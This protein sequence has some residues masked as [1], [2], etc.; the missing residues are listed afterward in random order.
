MMSIFR[1]MKWMLSAMLAA[2]VALPLAQPSPA[3][4]NVV[5]IDV[6]AC[7]NGISILV[8]QEDA[9]QPAPQVDWSTADGKGTSAGLVGKITGS[10]VPNG[11][12]AQFVYWNSIGLNA[13][14]T[15]QVIARGV[16]NDAYARFSVDGE[17]PPL[18]SVR[19]SAFEDLNHNGIRDAGE[20][21]IGT[22]SWKLT[23]GGDWFICGYVG[24]DSTFGPTVTPGTYT[25]IP[26]AQPGWVATTPPRSALVKRLGVAALDNDIGFAR[27]ANSKGQYCSQYA[28]PANVA[29]PLPAPAQAPTD[30]LAANGVFT[31]LLAGLNSTGLA[32][33]VNGPGAYTIIAPTDAA[34]A[35][36]SPAT[37]RRLASNP[38]ALEELLRCH[39]ILGNVDLGSLGPRAKAFPTLGARKVFLQVRNGQLLVNGVVV[40]DAI[41]TSNGQI[42]VPSRVL[43]V[44]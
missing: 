7:P 43:F 9:T 22:A 38:K 40:G 37:Q 19:G 5:G 6:F 39:I 33:V 24:G 17:C 27:A 25:V 18:G 28:P 36:L 16:R 4:A 31:K 13:G 32:G 11:Q 34:F 30:V 42:W 1:V 29:V 44:R 10:D 41:P 12:G 26:V 3:S 20:P 14:A 35:A 21:N 23:A 8:L 2:G 15:G